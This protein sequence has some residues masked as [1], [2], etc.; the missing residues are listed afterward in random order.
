MTHSPSDSASGTEPGAPSAA[1]EGLDLHD[2]V[3]LHRTT[4]T[5]HIE[6]ALDAWEHLFDRISVLLC[7]DRPDGA[8]VD[9]F[10]ELAAQ[11]RALALQDSD[12]ALF[13]LI[14]STGTQV[15]HYSE[16]HAMACLVICELAALWMDWPEEERQ[17]LALAALSMNLSMTTLQDTLAERNG[18]LSQPQR[19]RVDAHAAQSADLL[20]SAGVSNALWLD[21]VRHHHTVYGPQ[22]AS[23]QEPTPRLAELLRR[24]DIYLAKLSQRGAR[25]SVTPAKAARDACLDSDGHPDSI[26]ATLLR[27][28]GLY[29]PGTYVE[30][31]NGETGVVIQRGSKAHIPMVASVRRHDWGLI[32]PPQLR[33]TSRPALAVKRGVEPG[34][35]RVLFD[36]FHLLA[37]K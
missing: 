1:A 8:W 37:C 33:D 7:V 6:Q 26:G 22:A 12:L 24:V 25:D 14:Q 27:V 31:A 19:E 17:S 18:P 15:D 5:A 32:K 34:H 16:H 23:A 35:V 9:T 28:I 2:G 11:V 36:H 10:T 4:D 3:G 30:L 21:V 29:P 13:V 20:S